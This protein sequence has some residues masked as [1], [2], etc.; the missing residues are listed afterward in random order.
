MSKEFIAKTNERFKD[1]EGNKI[2]EIICV[3][4]KMDENIQREVTVPKACGTFS[5][6]S[7][8]ERKA[9]IIE[10]NKNVLAE[11]DS[12]IEVIQNAESQS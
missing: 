10:N 12:I 3:E 11:I 1:K 6:K 8:N 5:L 9:L 2:Y 7:A 4:T